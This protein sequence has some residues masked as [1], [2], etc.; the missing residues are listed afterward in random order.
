MDVCPHPDCQSLATEWANGRR[1]IQL[2]GLRLF[3][4]AFAIGLAGSGLVHA[5]TEVR[6]RVVYLK[7]GK[8]ARGQEIVLDEGDPQQMSPAVWRSGSK[9]P[10]ARTSADGVAIFRL[11]EPLP[12][13]VSVDVEN[14]RIIGCAWEGQLRLGDVLKQGVTVGA[15]ERYGSS[16]RGDRGVIKRL[17]AKPGEIAIFVRKITIWDDLRWY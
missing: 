13:T 6:V 11:D 3:T 2:T 1:R 12:E 17:A 15:D 16:C 10:R 4:A 5:Q 8:P 14:G 9:T 7:S